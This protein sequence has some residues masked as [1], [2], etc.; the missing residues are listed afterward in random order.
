MCHAEIVEQFSRDRVALLLTGKNGFAAL[1][2]CLAPHH[3]VRHAASALDVRFV[4]VH[5]H[6][7][8]FGQLVLVADGELRPLALLDDAVRSR[9]LFGGLVPIFHR[10]VVCDDLV[11]GQDEQCFGPALV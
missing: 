6:D 10:I 5:Q 9:H 8:F 1:R 3:L 4:V 2:V 7:V 11:C